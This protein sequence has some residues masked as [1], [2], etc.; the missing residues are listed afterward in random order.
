MTQPEKTTPARKT[1]QPTV[2]RVRQHCAEYPPAHYTAQ[3]MVTMALVIEQMAPDRD[4]VE[5]MQFM[6]WATGRVIG[7]VS[8]K[9]GM[10]TETELFTQGLT[11][12]DEV[13]RDKHGKPF[14]E[15]TPSK[16]RA[17]LESIEDGKATTGYWAQVPSDYFYRRF[18]TKLLH[19]MFAER[20]EWVQIGILR[21]ADPGESSPASSAT[22]G[23]KARRAVA[24]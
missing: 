4:P 12:I 19:G 24:E 14:A 3:S 2:D 10:P 23:V 18:Y 11:A 17:I 6:D 21:S 20:K 1:T 13:C 15:L 7:R 22:P 16:R 5:L 8:R 9:V